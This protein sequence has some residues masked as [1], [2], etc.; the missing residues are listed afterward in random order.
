MFRLHSCYYIIIFKILRDFT[1]EML[2]LDIFFL[3]I[4]ISILNRSV[5][6]LRKNI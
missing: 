6:A 2:E 5:A 1:Q 3:N 4:E